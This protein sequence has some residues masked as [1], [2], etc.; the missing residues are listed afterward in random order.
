MTDVKAKIRLEIQAPSEQVKA[1]AEQE[2]RETPER[3]K[4]ATNALRELLK[5]DK[6]LYFRDDDEF[7]IRFLRPTKFYPESALQLMKRAA[8]F[9]KKNANILDNLMP[10]DEENAFLENAVVNVLVDRDQKGRRILVTYS[11]EVWDPS[12]VTSDQIFRIFYLI[13]LAALQEPQSQ[14]CGA[15]VIMDFEG[16]GMK[17]VK[18]LTP[19]FSLRLLTFIQE[20][21]PLR[22]KEVHFVN[23]P[24]LFNMVWQMFKPFVKE[25]LKK[26]M[27]F[28]G[29][30]MESLHKHIDP[31]NLPE[32]YGGKLPKVNYS[33]VD[34]Y[35]VLRTLDNE[36]KEWN[37]FGIVQK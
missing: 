12:K 26:R 10:A 33:S 11:G 6:T 35:P 37:S 14:I 36:F 16:L 17:Q 4:E 15:V 22:L 23:Q 28:H 1:V 19:A 34:W 2:L 20:A 27:F 3:V 8:E 30:D 5:A 29:T 24:F 9:K 18:G 31:A 32:N 25:K 21:M 13:H 7:L